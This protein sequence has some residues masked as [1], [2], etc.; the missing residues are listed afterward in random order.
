MPLILDQE[1][2]FIPI[3]STLNKNKRAVQVKEHCKKYQWV[4]K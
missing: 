2:K 3:E 1:L 4:L